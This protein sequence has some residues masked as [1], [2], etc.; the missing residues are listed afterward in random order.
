MVWCTVAIYVIAVMLSSATAED[1]GHKYAEL[2]KRTELKCL[3][4]SDDKLNPKH[5]F[6]ANK[7]CVIYYVHNHKSGGTTMCRTARA[8]GYTVNMQRNC[9]APGNGNTWTKESIAKMKLTFVAQEDPYFQPD[10]SQDNYLY[11]T[12][13]RDPYDRIVSDLHHTLCLGSLQHAQE[14]IRNHSC[15]FNIRTASLT[16]IVTDKC[17]QGHFWYVSRNY[18]LR[19]FTG[20]EK[21]RCNEDSL[22]LAKDILQVMSVLMI[23][24]TPNDFVRCVTVCL[25]ACVFSLPFEDMA[26]YWTSSSPCTTTRASAL[27]PIRTPMDW[28]SSN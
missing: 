6:N 17:F 7:G 22:Q 19:M 3:R 10:L 5:V 16:D 9:N 1:S 28:C 27:G 23:T 15:S 24:D 18:Y 12:T 25:S 20:C 13:I 8:A 11:M 2:R 4:E 26:G 21:E 14:V